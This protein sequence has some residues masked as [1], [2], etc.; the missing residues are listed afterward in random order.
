VELGKEVKTHAEKALELNPREDTALHCL[1]MWH[2]EMA[3]MSG[4]K[5]FFAEMIY[6]NFPP[7]SL[8]EA[9]A[10]FRKAIEI[11][12]ASVSHHTEYGVTLMEQKKWSEAKQQLEKALRLA[13]VFPTDGQYQDRAKSKLEEV[14][15]KLK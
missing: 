6:G 3:T 9:A 15:K 5:K 13:K 11:N 2:R 1:G 7:A 12:D 8:D 10:S 14:N 4:F